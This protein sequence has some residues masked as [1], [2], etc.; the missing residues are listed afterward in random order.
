MQGS[1]ADW[2]S[3]K[4]KMSNVSRVELEGLRDIQV[5]VSLVDWIS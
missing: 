5:K 3:R 4:G 2:G 1:G